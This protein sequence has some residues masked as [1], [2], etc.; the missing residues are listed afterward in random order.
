MLKGGLTGRHD[1]TDIR[2]LHS[3]GP[4][5]EDPSQINQ[6]IMNLCINAFQA[7]EEGKGRINILVR[8][9]DIKPEETGHPLDLEPEKY[10]KIIVD[11]DRAITQMLEKILQRLGYKVMV[12]N[13]PGKALERIRLTPDSFDL[14]ITDMT[15]P[16]MTGA[17]LARDLLA[18][19]KN[20]PVIVCS[21]HSDLINEKT[22]IDS[23]IA[24]YVTKPFVIGRISMV[25][26]DV[27]DRNKI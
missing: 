12:F 24:A 7:M 22:A 5:L 8:K 18:L 17:D 16:E 4:Y 1:A 23:G 9:V 27:L 21:G 19:R 13:D 3:A 10:V 15:M 11:D 14:V 20:L 2:S 26:R 25:I 6:V